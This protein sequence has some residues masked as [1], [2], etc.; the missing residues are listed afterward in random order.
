MIME[1]YGKKTQT[2]FHVPY[3]NTNY[4]MRIHSK[5]F[6]TGLA[7]AQGWDCSKS[8]RVPGK[9]MYSNEMI[10]FDLSHATEISSHSK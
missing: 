6:C 10:V 3:N 7:M 8:Y 2:S 5:R 4:G 1:K 9:V